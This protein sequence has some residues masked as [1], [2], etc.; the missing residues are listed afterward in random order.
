MK[1]KYNFL[2]FIFI[3][4]IYKIKFSVEYFRSKIQRFIKKSHNSI[5]VVASCNR[6]R[7][8]RL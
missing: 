5:M 8:Q 6:L 4:R 3:M 7:N 1:S 2:M